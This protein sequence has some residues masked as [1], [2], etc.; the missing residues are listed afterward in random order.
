MNNN[1]TFSIHQIG[2]LIAM[3]I[4]AV[5][6][7]WVTWLHMTRP[8]GI[9]YT[10]I[11]FLS[12]VVPIY[13]ILVPFYVMR[14]RWSYIS[15]IFVVLILFAGVVF[16]AVV[17]R[18]FFF[19]FSVYNLTTVV[20]LLSAG[21]CIYFS[22]RSYLEL[23]SIGW[24][25]STIGVGI[26]LAI[27]ALVVWQVST[28]EMQIADYNREQVIHGVQTRTGDIDQLD[29]KIEALMD[30]G[31]IPSLTASIVINDEI[32][33]IRGYGEQ[34]TLNQ[35]HNIASMTKPF[36]ATAVLQLHDQGLID[37]DDDVN[38]YLPFNV[39]HPDYPDVP[40]TIH[41]LLS[42]RSCLAHKTN[43]YEAHLLGPELR[44]WWMAIK[45]LEYREELDA[46]SY[47]EFMAGYLNPDGAY[48]QPTVWAKCQPGSQFVYSTPG[49]DLLGYLV[50]Q[51]SGQPFNDYLYENIFAPLR[52]TN[53]TATPID[54]PERIAVPRE[55]IYGVLTKTNVELPLTQR[56]IIGG[57]GLYSTAGDLA[58]FLLAHMNQGEFEG[59]QLLQRETATLMHRPIRSSGGA[60]MQRGYGYGWGTFAE[61]PQQM[62]DIT[63]QPRGHQGHGGGFYGYSGAMF[64]VEEEQGAYG[65]VLLTNTNEV[66]KR[67]WP[68]KFA[69]QINIQDLIL[70]EAY[71][72]YQDVLND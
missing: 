19:S 60:F 23:P 36:V 50:E 68:W 47:P 51:V 12:A 25:K 70:S 1:K 18:V 4:L 7:I 61:E 43:Q 2:A 26:L 62:G 30:E 17:A 38:Q 32:V 67:D 57:G 65:Y 48:F 27:S 3:I 59:Y 10:E 44:P 72:M 55:R 31:D 66:A 28:N 16:A 41:M 13:L 35:M 9:D 37:L 52:M 21:A 34:D 22:L 20:V 53:T 45:D 33:W 24:L 58:S 46:L 54:T 49:F 64:M 15:G 14:V 6:G 39:R 8:L 42:N 69:I 56:R 5:W 40:I 11:L 71:V 29:E 63:F